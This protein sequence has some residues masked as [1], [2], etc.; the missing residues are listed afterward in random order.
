MKQNDVEFIWENEHA[1]SQENSEKKSNE[2]GQSYQLCKYS[3]EQQSFE[4]YGRDL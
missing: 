3:L 2:G 1:N 4:Y